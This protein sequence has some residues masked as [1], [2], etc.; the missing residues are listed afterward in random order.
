MK[1]KTNGLSHTEGILNGNFKCLLFKSDPLGDIMDYHIM[2]YSIHIRRSRKI[3]Q[4]EK[5]V[6]HIEYVYYSAFLLFQ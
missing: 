4:N 5:G 3:H 1:T 2:D 6:N